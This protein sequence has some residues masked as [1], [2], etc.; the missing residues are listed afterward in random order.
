MARIEAVQANS[1]ARVHKSQ[2]T[3]AR[4]DATTADRTD[5][6][7]STIAEDRYRGERGERLDAD[8][9]AGLRERSAPPPA[10]RRGKPVRGLGGDDDE[11]ETES[12]P[13]RRR[14]TKPAPKKE[15]PKKGQGIIQVPNKLAK[16]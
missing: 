3:Q 14:P 16:M 10:A 5:A 13:L 11:S 15:K 8:E 9:V 1:T 6:V 2:E 4:P 7:R 12:K